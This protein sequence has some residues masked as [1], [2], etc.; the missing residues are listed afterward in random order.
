VDAV[1]L[2]VVGVTDDVILVADALNRR[3]DRQ[4]ISDD[5]ILNPSLQGQLRL[6]V[7]TTSLVTDTGSHHVLVVL[8]TGADG[9]GVVIRRPVPTLVLAGRVNHQALDD[10]CLSTDSKGQR[11]VAILNPRH[12]VREPSL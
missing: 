3:V 2:I 11:V 7:L 1:P 6:V 12:A 10:R 9:L 5:R 4:D 8:S